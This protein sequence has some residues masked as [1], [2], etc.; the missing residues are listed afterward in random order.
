MADLETVVG[1]QPLA[2]WEFAGQLRHSQAA[3]LDAV[4]VVSGSPLHIVAPPGSGK[5]L[6]GLLLAMRAGAPALVL[7]PTTTIRGQWAKTARQLAA[8]TWGE[9]EPQVPLAEVSEDPRAIGDLTA[10]TYQMLGTIDSSSPF[11]QLA[12]RAWVAEL[13]EGGRSI[14][15][16]ESW[17][18]H[19]A[20]A[21]PKAHRQGIRRRAG[22]LRKEVVREDP[23]RL[24]EALHPNARE[25]IER[26]V[27]RGV[28]TL[29]LD[30]CHHLLDY[31]AIVVH[32][33]AGRIRERGVEPVIVGLTATLPSEED[34]EAYENYT[35]LLGDV[36]Y[37]V[38]TPAVV[39]EGNLAPYRD[40]V[41]FVTPEDDELEFLS[42]QQ[43]RF[44]A[45]VKG[46]LET[47]EGVEF[48]AQKLCGQRFLN[49]KSTERD[50]RLAE[51]FKLDFAFTEAA[52]AVLAEVS[53]GHLL[54]RTLGHD[55]PRGATM[56]QRIRV[57]ARYAL[58]HMLPDPAR[59][60]L[61]K[62]TRGLLSDLGYHL[63]DRGIR[64][65]RDPV[66]QVLATSR[67]KDLAVGEILR[68]EMSRE[69]REEIR[70]VVILDFA[71][72]GHGVGSG[73]GR[74]GALRCFDSVVEDPTLHAFRP[75]LMTAQHLRIAAR[76]AAILV[77]KLREKL[78]AEVAVSAEHNGVL[79]LE[80]PGTGTSALVEAVSQMIA[81][82]VVR[83]L[84]GTRGLLGEGWDCPAINTLID[85][86][87]SS[88]SA[89]TQ[90]LRGR[91]LRIDPGWPAKVAH[92]WT[93]T[94]LPKARS[95]IEGASDVA[96]MRRK[97][98]K[99]WGITVT[100]P[101]SVVRGLGHTLTVAQIGQLEQILD[102]VATA[103]DVR[104]LNSETERTLPSRQ[105]TRDR[106][107][108]GEPYLGQE[109]RQLVARAET[110]GV[111]RSPP[112][113]DVLL[114]MLLGGAGGIFVEAL[115]VAL[116][117]SQ[118]DAW[119]TLIIAALGIALFTYLARDSIRSLFQGLR[120]FALP[121]S[122]YQGAALALA[123]T[124]HRRGDSRAFGRANIVVAQVMATP[125]V[126]AHHLVEVKGGNIAEQQA[127]LGGLREIFGPIRTPRFLLEVGQ[128]QLKWPTALTWFAGLITRLLTR[129]SRF[130]NVP[131]GVARR[132]EDA[133]V[134]AEEWRRSVGPCV[135]HE[136]NSSDQLSLLTRARR[137]NGPALDRSVVR[138]VWA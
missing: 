57:L 119:V 86:S 8:R 97:Q 52:A 36:D 20:Q 92:N 19:L 80:T 105:H 113:L 136:I 114:L 4:D 84:V 61:W 126:V 118:G 54:L 17:L 12:E 23:S 89:A 70:A 124:L 18:E 96:R 133:M 79:T 123:R 132:R 91:S 94:C 11:D 69:V 74:A 109:R 50:R 67:S 24:E 51:A 35:G 98:S 65:G 104:W 134:F 1:A 106:W 22:R 82:G 32:C 138:D 39:K 110:A 47:P 37:E 90:Q 131:R 78:N 66:D 95:S 87:T 71:V 128:S 101:A 40:A 59:E 103:R 122:A 116:R 85:L 46:I 107:G 102:K 125:R 27:E 62:D 127:I 99:S 56:E 121:G 3:I 108:I 100:E 38:P 49:L 21:N 115:R 81:E 76:D 53:P 45:L 16:A 7:S 117:A 5:T 55:A 43:S 83:L 63:T 73:R 75:V 26:L 14:P 6:V 130:V 137:S 58:E 33:L 29:I 34:Q 60:Q 93:V 10:L 2:E 111:L 30:E 31:W 72:H 41:W 42:A 88:T 112:T 135:L 9:D 44:E 77:P 13:V 25:L 68:L 64:R 15:D 129:R 120:S 28:T 48:L